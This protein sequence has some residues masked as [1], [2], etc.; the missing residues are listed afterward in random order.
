MR[1]FTCSSLRMS[2]RRR[3]RSRLKS[4][5]VP[6]SNRSLFSFPAVTLSVGPSH[7]ESFPGTLTDQRAHALI[8]L[9]KKITDFSLE[10]EVKVD[11]VSLFFFLQPFLA[12][13]TAFHYASVFRTTSTRTTESTCSSTT[14]TMRRRNRM[15][16]EKSRVSSLIDSP[17]GSYFLHSSP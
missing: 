11:N 3:R 7:K 8:N 16:S 6:Y 2:E 9:S 15:S 10:E 4:S 14:P 5:S 17:S 13:L 12:N 1:F